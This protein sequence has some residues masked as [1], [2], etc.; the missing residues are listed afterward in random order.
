VERAFT[1]GL[2]LETMRNDLSLKQL[3]S[4]ERIAEFTCFQ[5]MEAKRLHE[6]QE[7]ERTRLNCTQ[8]VEVVTVETKCKE[9]VQELLMVSD[10]N[11]LLSEEKKLKIQHDTEY[12]IEVLKQEDILST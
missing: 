7:T 5:D 9:K 3:A 10:E 11:K 2:E 1:K 6:E 4:H 8:A 12:K